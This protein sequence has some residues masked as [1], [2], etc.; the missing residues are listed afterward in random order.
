MGF[1][2]I[3]LTFR[4][5]SLYTKT[6]YIDCLIKQAYFDIKSRRQ[7]MSKQGDIRK[8]CLQGGGDSEEKDMLTISLTTAECERG[9]S[10]VNNIKITA[11][12]SMKQ[13]A[14]SSLV[15]IKVDGPDLMEYNPT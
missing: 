14:L 3:K 4:I 12:T 11:R 9:F 1:G 2:S 15:R 10:S 6:A 8:F 7:Y 13:E 5:L